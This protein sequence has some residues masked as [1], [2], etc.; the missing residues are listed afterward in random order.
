MEA[1]RGPKSAAIRYLIAVSLAVA[2]VALRAAMSPWLQ[3]AF[4][5]TTLFAAVALTVWIAGGVPAAAA[6]LLG[7]VLCYLFFVRPFT[8]MGFFDAKNLMGLAAFSASSGLIIWFG[9]ALR[10]ANARAREERE[11]LRITLNSLGEGVL[12]CDQ[13]ANITFINPVAETLTGWTLAEAIG[14][15]FAEVFRIVDERSRASIDNPVSRVLN[16]GMPVELNEHTVLVARDGSE[17]PIRGRC[18]PLRSEGGTPGGGVVVFRDDGAIRVAQLALASSERE[19]ADFFE[20]ASMGLH[21]VGPDGII[22]KVN[23]SELA[24]LGYDSSEYVGR[25]ISE[26]HVDQQNISDI[27]RRLA[28]GETLKDHPARLR[29]KDGSVRDV[30]I[31]SN[32][33][34]QSGSFVHT[35]CFTRDVTEQV[36]AQ[37]A[38]RE[39]ERR[40]DEFLATLAHELRNP[41]ASLSNMLE[42][43]KR[44]G[45]DAALVSRA[46]DAMS[47][48][49][50]GLVRLVDD[51]LDLSRVTRNRLDLRK[52]PTELRGIVQ[53]AIDTSRPLIE[54]GSHEIEVDWPSEPI[55]VEADAMRLAQVF[56]NLCNNACK[57]SEPGGRIRISATR[58]ESQVVVC[59]RDHGIGIPPEQ[60]DRI[61]EMFA[62]VD[63]SLERARGGLGIGLTLVKRLV[64]LHGGAVRVHSDGP[65][66]GSEF[67]VTL[68]TIATVDTATESPVAVPSA[69]SPRRVLVVDDNADSAS[70]LAL[71][72]QMEG[73]EVMTASDGLA[74]IELAETFRPDTVLLDIGLPGMN[75]LDVARRLRTY[76][77]G[78]QLVL[79]AFTGWGQDSD[80]RATREAGF[81][82]HMVKP[83]DFSELLGSLEQLSAR[84][85]ARVAPAA[86]TPGTRTVSSEATSG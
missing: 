24:M 57:F 18:S 21:W 16:D 79:I 42:L 8:D 4:P 41:L 10:K 60:V 51:L 29:C 45:S 64:E 85:R 65:K 74:A 50:D 36:R 58:K 47:R 34:W 14:K 33:L 27:L 62:Q 22:L 7:Y 37:Q 84:R 6:A 86:L 12:S 59:V 55:H 61:F 1:S 70:S 75:G 63:R 30:L 35:R 43:L 23:R 48:Q 15:P 2:A 13:D 32:V 31:N 52:E 67:R 81:D 49:L 25:H 9:E 11:S 28:A 73:H 83:V 71:L 68:P 3:D 54:A 76:E 53:H 77:S 44:A 82:A 78:A 80:R 26:F 5:L 46:R 56:T 40:K 19:H 69:G 72:L 39:A 20:N 66:R 38:V 17:H